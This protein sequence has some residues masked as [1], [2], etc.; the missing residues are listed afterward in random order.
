MKLR[1]VLCVPPRAVLSV[2]VCRGPH[3]CVSLAVS[4]DLRAIGGES[5]GEIVVRIH[6]WWWI[7]IAVVVLQLHCHFSFHDN[8]LPLNTGTS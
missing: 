5:G 2:A 8:L 1:T 7:A 3:G 6:C 4:Y